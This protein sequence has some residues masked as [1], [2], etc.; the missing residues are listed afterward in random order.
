MKL[1]EE[2]ALWRYRRNVSLDN[3]L[4]QSVD[5]VTYPSHRDRLGDVWMHHGDNAKEDKEGYLLLN[6]KRYAASSVAVG[7][8]TST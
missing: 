2:V 4:E 8:A 3:C 1:S 5:E 7:S 6:H